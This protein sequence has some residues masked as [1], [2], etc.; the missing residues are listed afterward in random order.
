MPSPILPYMQRSAYFGK[1][2]GSKLNVIFPRKTGI[3]LSELN[4]D[5]NV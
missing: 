4:R 2:V 3:L 5:C 1:E